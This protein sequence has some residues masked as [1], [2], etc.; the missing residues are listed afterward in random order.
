MLLVGVAGEAGRA[1]FF[2]DEDEAGLS[3]ESLEGGFP[4]VGDG[5]EDLVGE[6]DSE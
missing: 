6:D 5:A 2:V 4:F 3:L 1:D